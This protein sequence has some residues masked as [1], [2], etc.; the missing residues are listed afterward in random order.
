MRR[1]YP[2]ARV[3]FHVTN[4]TSP[5]TPVDLKEALDSLLSEAHE[6]DVEIDDHAFDLRHVDA[7][8]PDWEV[9]I[10]RLAKN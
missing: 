4:N 3:I 2:R 7:T 10:V 9:L 6:N 1:D 5:A 8:A